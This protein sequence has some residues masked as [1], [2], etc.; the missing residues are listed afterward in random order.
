MTDP[1]TKS[2]AELGREMNRRFT[3]AD[4]LI[5]EIRVFQQ[6]TRALL[7]TLDETD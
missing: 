4:G 2:A 6:D 7:A 3:A 1:G 5:R